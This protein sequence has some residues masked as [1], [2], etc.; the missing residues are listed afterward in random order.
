M[1]QVL[2]T[3][4]KVLRTMYKRERTIYKVEL[5]M[6]HVVRTLHQVLHT[7]RHVYHTKQQIPA[8]IPAPGMVLPAVLLASIQY[9]GCS[10]LWVV[11][12]LCWAV[13]TS[14]ADASGPL[15]AFQELAPNYAGILTGIS[16]TVATLPGFLAPQITGYL[17]QDQVGA[18]LIIYT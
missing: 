3:M 5:T 17:T 8:S 11:F 14:G 15:C 10:R 4:Y 6:F 16:N 18:S 12:L 9:A 2:R 13:G 7:M 1:Y